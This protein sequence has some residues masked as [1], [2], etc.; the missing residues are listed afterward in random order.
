MYVFPL[1]TCSNVVSKHCLALATGMF[2]C[3]CVCVS[4]FCRRDWSHMGPV[5]FVQISQELLGWKAEK[6]HERKC[7]EGLGVLGSLFSRWVWWLWIPI[8]WYLYIYISIQLNWQEAALTMLPERLV[9]FYSSLLG[10]FF[11]GGGNHFFEFTRYIHTYKTRIYYCTYIILISINISNIH[12]PSRELAY[13]PKMAFWRWF[14]FS[15]GG[16]C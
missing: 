11:W 3:V 14:S 15:Q 7:S 1:E 13:P 12:I 10:F 6:V 4:Y 8:L 9:G 2:K 5:S 16:I